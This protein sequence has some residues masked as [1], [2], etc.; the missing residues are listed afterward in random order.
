MVRDRFEEQVK[1]KCSRARCHDISV[2]EE[3][4]PWLPDELQQAGQ[5]RIPGTRRQQYTLHQQDCK[6]VS[7]SR[8]MV[9]IYHN[10]GIGAFNSLGLTP[11][12]QVVYSLSYWSV[13][14]HM[15]AI[16]VM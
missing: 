3:L 8:T 1:R 6:R 9:G 16:L 10:I 7:L 15:H 4:S 12:S 11:K 5:A 14:V 2:N 13:V